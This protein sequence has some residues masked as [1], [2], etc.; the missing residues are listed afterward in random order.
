MLANRN[1]DVYTS[2]VCSAPAAVCV[3]ASESAYVDCAFV[4]T[5]PTAL[6]RT[7]KQSNY[8]C[9]MPDLV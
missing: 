1:S 3:V 6:R 2:G 5:A 9:A 8:F 7:A 4:I